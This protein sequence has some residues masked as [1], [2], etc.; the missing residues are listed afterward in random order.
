M[1]DG[2]FNKLSSCF[3]GRNNDEDNIA[4][5]TNK[6]KSVPFDA[7]NED[8]YEDQEVSILRE[9]KVKNKREGEFNDLNNNNE[10]ITKSVFEDFN[11]IVDTLE[12]GLIMYKLDYFTS[13]ITQVIVEINH[14]NQKYLLSI[15]KLEGLLHEK[16][17]CKS[18][19]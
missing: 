6:L 15:K 3:G 8:S 10:K 5:R 18:F 12:K 11:K 13:N 17:T 16:E 14:V 9:N 2:F 4:N 1:F 7:S 19:L